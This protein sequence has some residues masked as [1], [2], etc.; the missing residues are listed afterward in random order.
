MWSLLAIW[1]IRTKN[2]AIIFLMKQNTVFLIGFLSFIACLLLVWEIIILPSRKPPA[3]P[4]PLPPAK[5]TPSLVP[6]SP[7]ITAAPSIRT[8]ADPLKRKI[9]NLLPVENE[10]FSI[11]YSAPVDQFIVIIRRQPV[12]TYRKKAEQWFKDRGV[13]NLKRFNILWGE[14]RGI[15]GR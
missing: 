13:K 3:S 15:T 8:T 14:T 2:N 9:I 6:P 11:E 1:A 7:T 12:N 10:D 4:K 5:I